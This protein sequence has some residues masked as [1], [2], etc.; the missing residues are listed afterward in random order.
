MK[1]E[2][3]GDFVDEMERISTSLKNNPLDLKVNP[4]AS[5]TN[6]AHVQNTYQQA[7]GSLYAFRQSEDEF[8]ASFL[9]KKIGRKVIRSYYRGLGEFVFTS[10]LVELSALKAIQ[11]FKRTI[12]KLN[13]LRS[14]VY[15]YN[16]D[17]VDDRQETRREMRR[18]V[19]FVNGLNPEKQFVD[20]EEN[21][22]HE[23]HAFLGFVE[24]S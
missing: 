14:L 16:N 19:N 12:T 22:F 3:E 17:L 9:D 6:I 5:I 21:L 10:S 11:H 7:I 18:I 13:I 1:R 2:L 20:I 23:R 8:I 15:Q 24:D 4:H